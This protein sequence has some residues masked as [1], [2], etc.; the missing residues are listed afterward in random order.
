[1]TDT[2][3]WSCRSCCEKEQTTYRYPQDPELYCSSCRQPLT[4]EEQALVVLRLLLRTN[5]IGTLFAKE[6]PNDSPEEQLLTIPEAAELLGKSAKALYAQASRG[7]LPG[8]VR[9]GRTLRVRQSALLGSTS[10]GRVSP[11][12][13]RR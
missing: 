6:L 5:Q 8:T 13:T 1:M 11:G 2:S 9:V 10:E 4:L 7:S 12:R 3:A